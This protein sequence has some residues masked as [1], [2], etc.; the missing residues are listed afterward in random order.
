M[1][2]SQ[3]LA[4]TYPNPDQ[5]ALAKIGKSVAK[6]LSA[7]PA[8]ARLP[9]DQLE[10]HS[11]HD[12]LTAAECARMCELIDQV[13]RPS[14]LYDHGYGADYRTSASGDVDR[15]DPLVRTIEARIDRLL[16]IPHL[17]GEPLQ[18]QR[19]LPGQ[20]FKQHYD[21]F[22]TKA[23]YWADEAGRGGQRCYTAMAYLSE[24]EEG[25]STDF[26][27]I[28]LSIP[29]QTGTLIVWNNATPAGYPSEASMHAGTPVL[30][31]AKYV[32]TKWYRTRRF[33]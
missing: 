4:E 8:V 15:T 19:Y 5:S 20:Q 28:D 7:N 16:G 1:A 17:Y 9:S 25:G 18:G 6:R 23:P 13:A 30:R 27:H 21:W 10:I 14:D 22:Y 12:F 33:G 11:V 2:M 31:G 32:I 3:T 24:V 26:T 29:P